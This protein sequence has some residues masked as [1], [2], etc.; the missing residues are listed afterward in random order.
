[1][2]TFFRSIFVILLLCCFNSKLRAQCADTGAYSGTT[3][4]PTSTSQ[5]TP[6]IEAEEHFFM[7]ITNGGI[8]TVSVCGLATWDTQLTIRDT[9]G[10][11]IAYND[12][13]CGLQSEVSFTATYTGQAKIKLNRFDCRGSGR[14]VSAS[15]IE[16][17]ETISTP[18]LIIDDISVDEDAGTM[19]FTITHT[20]TNTSG[21]FNADYAIN[22]V[23]ATE[24]VDYTTGSGIYTGT[25]SF[26]GTAG[27]T[28]QITVLITD[29]FDI[30]PNETYVIQ[31]TSVTDSS[32]DITD[33][34]IG[35]I[36][37]DD[38]TAVIQAA[39]ISVDED[40]GTATF[41]VNHTG[42]SR[43]LAFTVDYLITAGT[44]TE[45][46][47]YTTSS[48]IYTG[49]L[50]FN[51]TAGDTDQITVL[52]T[53]DTDFESSETLT[54]S[55]S[56]VSDVSVNITDTAAATINDNEVIL[57]DVPL[58]LYDDFH[59]NY[60]YVVAGGSLRT[61]SNTANACSIKTS[62]SANLTSILPAA[63]KTVEKA[64][65][66]WSHSNPTID[67]NVTFEGTTVTSDLIYG[68]SFSGAQFYGY[69]A[70]VTDIVAG[71]ANPWSNSYDFS[72]LTIDNSNTYCSSAVVLGTWSLM[73]FY[74]DLSLPAST[75]NLYYGFDVTQNN[76]TTFTLDNFYAISPTGSKATFLSY[77]GDL[78]LDGTSGTNKEE[79]SILPEGAGA[80]SILSGDGL[81]TGNNP[82]NSTIYDETSGYNQTGTYGLDLDT[83]DI[84][85]F[86]SSFDTQVTANVD[87]GQDLV[88]SSAV[89]LRVPSNLISGNVFEDINYPGGAGRNQVA[90]SGVGIED[91]ILELYD[92]SGSLY[93]TQSTDASGNYNFGGMPDGTY[94]VRVINSSVE[95]TRGG[96]ATCSSCYGVQT[97]RTSYNGTSI[98]EVFNE[99]GGANPDQE[100]SN[101][102]TLIGAQSVST[103]VISNGGIG[104]IDFGFNF[105][106]IVN[107]NDDG[108]GSLEQFI[109]NANNLDET[110]LDIEANSIFDPA[111]GEDTSIFMI[112][113]TGDILLRIADTGYTSGY[114]NILIPDGN[115]IATIVG[116]NTIIDGRTQTAYS[117]DTNTGNVGSGGSLVGRSGIALPNFNRPEIQVHK[118]NGDVLNVEGTNVV[119]RNIS[120]YAGN[121]AGIRIQNGNASVLESFLGV[122]ALGNN[123]GNIDYGV[124][125]TGG[126]VVVDGNYIATNVDAG[127]FINGGT[128]VI[129]Q[130]NHISSNGNG[131]CDDNITINN[132]TGIVIQQN[133]IDG[134]A[135][136]G[137]DGDGITGNISL[138][139][140]SITTSGQNGGSCSGNIE[141]AGVLLDGNNSLISNNIIFS[142]AG[143][144]IVLAGGN[145]SGNLI[146]Q[147]S[148]YSNGTAGDALGIDLDASDSI[149]DGVT[150]NELNDG[151][152]GPNGL[153][154]FPLISDVFISGSEI[155]VT[156]WTRPGVTVELFL[157]DISQGSSVTGDN[158]LGQSVDY[159]EGQIYLGSFIE[160]SIADLDSSTSLYA[161]DDGNTDNTNK[162]KVKIAIPSS[163]SSGDLITATATLSNSTSEFSPFSMVRN[164]T[165]I[166]NRRITYRVKKE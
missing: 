104:N 98:N 96:G 111:S 122:N 65:L 165:V 51:G 72:G 105:N 94:S 135:S 12:D 10:G 4:T 131:A 136:L 139:E 160:G 36:N 19:L 134:A 91:V 89:V 92:N 50:S 74:E 26:N 146:T 162:F 67:Q 9:S 22:A 166:T 108:Q 82:Y 88:I 119:L 46:I 116:G 145:T 159:G 54:I 133:L 84:S 20:G 29:D 152:N 58:A 164:Y 48:G 43:P 63:G 55:F 28:D 163:V 18:Q 16:Y 153:L 6:S 66:Y 39:N 117:G 137:I 40:A 1:M 128:S 161:D 17:Y 11:F 78:T 95:S 64:Y 90:S 81:Q 109:V 52:I 21:A 157:T 14:R 33:T 38:A 37:N 138:I 41:T 7:N 106:T 86:I 114:F 148:F 93:D 2:K 130:N 53:D 70:D 100:D 110:G 112:P 118:N 123:A 87:M 32:V 144:G 142:N 154:N 42:G 124:E 115:P 69:I 85:S 35:T 77:E 60:D 150:L 129:I 76:G 49:T 73:I 3:V 140:N 8:Y 25:L 101:L 102:G 31:F 56:S 15:T 62:S 80:P 44:A 79:L 27:D 5:F 127:V 13:S 97:F 71:I 113:P 24:G 23:S 45:G 158:Q 83:Y 120:V 61:Q 147:N 156:G 99:I 103:V 47:D 121:N 34:A 149:G 59:G 57:Q 68:A 141:N 30:E 155:I 125:I 132:G 107:T 126:D 151:D 75:I 143:S